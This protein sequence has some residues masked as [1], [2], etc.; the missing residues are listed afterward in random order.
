[1][2]QGSVS[3]WARAPILGILTILA[4]ACSGG[5]SESSS[6]PDPVVPP[7]VSLSASPSA[8]DAGQIATLTWSSQDA[9]SCTAG[10]GWSGGKSLSG[11]EQI[12]PTT[13]TNYTLSCDGSGGSA[14]ASVTVQ[15]NGTPTPSP[16]VNFSAAD[17]VVADGGMTSLTWS[18]QNADTCTASGGWSGAKNLADSEQIGPITA[19]TTYTL[20]CTGAGGTAIE[21]LTV[22]ITTMVSLDW[23]APTENV[24]GTPLT[25][26]TAYR[27]YYGAGSRSYDDVLD[28]P[29]P[30]ATS[31]TVDLVSGTYYVAMTAI[32]G[33]GNESAYSNEVIKIAN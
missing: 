16:I 32:D 10:G 19:A 4:A 15:V 3:D 2:G 6:A 5:S 20:S 31:Y 24:D 21:M 13:S 11:S 25:D 22:L 12:S 33:D 14:S 30:A 7:S 28:L 9:S 8:I 18:S 1:M 27:I 23:V 26:L 17:S 29:D